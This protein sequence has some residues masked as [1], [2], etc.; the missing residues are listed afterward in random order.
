MEDYCAGPWKLVVAMLLRY[1]VLLCLVYSSVLHAANACQWVVSFRRCLKILLNLECI[2]NRQK[3]TFERRFI[4]PCK[5]CKHTV[6]FVGL[7]LP[8]GD[9]FDRTQ[10]FRPIEG[11]LKLSL[12]P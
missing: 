9:G 11:V 5:V 7:I 8:F 3:E 6:T 1:L 4:S 12:C 10:A 2:R